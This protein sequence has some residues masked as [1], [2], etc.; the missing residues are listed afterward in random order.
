MVVIVVVVVVV[1]AVVYCRACYG[2]CA[3]TMTSA[4]HNPACG[5]KVLLIG[6]GCC[7]L[8]VVVGCCLL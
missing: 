1:V 6:V 5:L 3:A 2:L 4:N 7:G 8:L